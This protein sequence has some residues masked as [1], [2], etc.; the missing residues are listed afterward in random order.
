MAIDTILREWKSR[1]FRPIYWLDGEEEYFIDKVVDYAEHNILNENEAAF[2]LTIF[3]GRDT[4][5]ADRCGPGS[6]DR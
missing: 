6:S 5:W 4:A 3:Y 1:T 2:N